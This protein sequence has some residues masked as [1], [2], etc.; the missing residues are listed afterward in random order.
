MLPNQEQRERSHFSHTFRTKGKKCTKMDMSLQ[1][2]G[3]QQIISPKIKPITSSQPL[4]VSQTSL[5]I[6]Q[7]DR[8]I[9]REENQ[10]DLI[11]KDHNGPFPVMDALKV[12]PE[13]PKILGPGLIHCIPIQTWFIDISLNHSSVTFIGMAIWPPTIIQFAHS[14][15]THLH[16]QS[17]THTRREQE[18]RF[19]VGFLQTWGWATS[20]AIAATI[21]CL[22]KLI[23]RP[24]NVAK[25][26]NRYRSHFSHLFQNQRRKHR[27][28]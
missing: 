16:P 4:Q 1:Q 15:S 9:D 12:E 26:R 13:D 17:R 24:S 28:R 14:N 21:S 18:I 20:S 19:S 22:S 7:I 8:Q 25:P 2:T 3:F 6:R 23:H 5:D 11:F 27:E 10:R